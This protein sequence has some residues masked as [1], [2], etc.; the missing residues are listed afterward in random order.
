VFLP[1]EQQRGLLR[2]FGIS[3][4]RRLVLI[5]A[6]LLLV[7][8]VWARDRHRSAVRTT[9]A[10][11]LVTHRAVATYR[12]DN[13]AACPPGGLEEL[14]ARKLLTHLP[15]DAWGH[16]LRL[17]CPSHRPGTPYDLSSDGPDEQPG[18]LDHV[19]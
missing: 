10:T 12:A 15:L 7:A 3:R 8:T 2:A 5:V 13:G 1:W 19:E 11:L 18:G 14:V 4:V 16:P 17:V 9:R 6:L